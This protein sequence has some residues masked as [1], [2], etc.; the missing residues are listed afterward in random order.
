MTFRLELFVDDLAASM[1]F[2]NRVLGFALG[3]QQAGNYVP[4]TNGD[5][6]LSLNLRAN[7]PDDHPIQ[8]V[9]GER[10][11]RG[12]ELVLEVNDIEAMYW[13]VQSANWPMSGELQHR[14]WGLT[15]FR[16]LDPNGYYW[17]ITTR[18]KDDH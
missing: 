4:M 10:L 9:V 13:H 17:R 6:Y 1:D 12:I 8:A 7:L 2:Y 5:V 11:G 14:P 3:K 18:R 16:V 15:D